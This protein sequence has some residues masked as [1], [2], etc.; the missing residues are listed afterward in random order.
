M[1]FNLGDIFVTFKAKAEGFQQAV[2]AVKNAGSQVK[3]VTDSIGDFGKKTQ[4]VG[5]KMTVGLT[6]PIVGFGV[7][8]F[9]S[10]A[11][12]EQ[13][14][15][16][17]EVAT[18]AGA[19]GIKSLSTLAEEM[20]AKTKFS[21]GEAAQ[22]M[23]ELAK[24]GITEAQIK[25][26]AL[27]ATMTLAAAGGID[28]GNAA[29]YVSN[30]LNTFGLRAE[31]ANAVAAAL[32]GGA[33]ASTASVESLGMALAQ[34]GP[35]AKLAGYSI[36]DTVAALAAFDN[37]GVKGSDAGTSL[38]TMLMGLNPT[39]AEAA[40]TMKKLGL[41]FTDAQG[42]FIPLREVAEQLQTKLAGLSDS[43]KQAALQ[44][45]F[46]TDA[47]RAAAILMNNGAEG[48]DKYAAAT[49]DLGAA[50]EMAAAMTSGSAG[51]I[52]MMMGSL[53]TAMKKVGDAIAPTVI[54]IADKIGQLADKFTKLDPNVQKVVVTVLAL[55]AAAGPL[56]IGIGMMARGIAAIGSGVSMLAKGFGLF[57]KAAVFAIN[58]VKMALTFLAM[59]PVVLIIMAIVLA[60][61]AAA[62]L[63]YKNWDTLKQWFGT[64]WEFIKGIF[65]AAWQWIV[66]NWQ[67]V[68]TMLLGPL[69]AFIALVITYWDQIKA[70]ALAVWNF[71]L[72]AV[73]FVINGII[74]YFQ[75]WLAVWTA[76]I[77][78]VRD[79]AVGVWNWIT[80]FIGR[81]IQGWINIISGIVGGVQWVFQQAINIVKNIWGGIGSWFGSVIDGIKGTFGRV[82]DIVSGPFKA[83]FNAIAG[84]WNNS[85]GS[86]KWKAPDWV[87]GIGGKEIGVPKLPMLAQGGI[88]DKATL[89]V[90]GEGSEPEAVIPLSKIGQVAAQMG[91]GSGGDT[92]NIQ[93]DGIMARS[94]SELRDIILEGLQAVDER[95]RAQGKPAILKGGA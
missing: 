12:F 27:D 16:Q 87:P 68:L 64:F 78:A 74:A 65:A 63:I 48:I 34:V 5:N 83:A 49:N 52:E 47:Y 31:D 69:G 32:A 33:N 45:M 92:Y 20:G 39:T 81:V 43:Q 67:L 84:F 57:G 86:L 70:A 15:K 28:L 89:A 42:K 79:I 25:A 17:V 93:L 29:G 60:L 76:I 38:K 72:D 8:A 9:K 73:K 55:A 11:S 30:A 58:G 36:Q 24:G 7:A 66:D 88:V 40:E 13:T 77:N 21:A 56:L 59:H 95:R 23:L 71:I 18:G 10:A 54:K 26:G 35:G 4:D 75:F 91:G 44:T 41:K 6:L 61:A 1:A 3:G 94:K 82:V 14:M 53:E 50:Q 90:I 2:Q 22:A 46:G 19:E 51:K 62:F 80:D 37:A 85:I